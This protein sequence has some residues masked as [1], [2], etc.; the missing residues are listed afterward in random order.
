MGGK[1]LNRFNIQTIRLNKNDYFN[2]WKELKPKFEKLFI[3]SDLILS[4]KNK[5]SFGDMDVLV[6]GLKNN[7]I[8]WKEEIQKEFN[9]SA[10][11]CNGNVYSFDY[12]KFQ[13]DVIKTKLKYYQSSYNYYNFNDTG[14][15]CGRVFNKIGFKYGYRGLTYV[16][17][18][19]N[20]YIL[21]EIDISQSRTEILDF[22]GFNT[23]THIDGFDNLED[24]FQ[25]II[26]SKYFNASIF[27]YENLNNENRVRNKKRETYKQFLQYLLDNNITGGYE[28]KSKDYYY[29]M[30]EEYFGIK[31]IDKINELNEKDEKIKLIREKF[32]GNIIMEITGLSC[33]KLGE[34]INKYKSSFSDFDDFIISSSDDMIKSHIQMFYKNK[35]LES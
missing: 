30:A 1:A 23:K 29:K 5:E 19:K 31:L 20:N 14:N 18:T 27:A 13:I 32:N 3:L 9:P 12:K 35:F 11:Y 4:Y 33:K 8:N 21:E 22:G 15:L 16:H 34:F 24:I 28:F 25:F 6:Y 7:K 10:I 26:N 2:L 17:R